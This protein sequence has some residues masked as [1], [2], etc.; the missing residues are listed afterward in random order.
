MAIRNFGAI[1]LQYFYRSVS[2][3]YILCTLRNPCV[4]G[5]A[6]SVVDYQAEHP[7]LI[8]VIAQFHLVIYFMVSDFCNLVL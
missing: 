7:G 6:I 2:T 8:P 5:T 3:P 4:G 1:K